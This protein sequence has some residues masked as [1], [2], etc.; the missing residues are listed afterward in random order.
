MSENHETA[1]S[2][3]RVAGGT[4]RKAVLQQTL[5]AA[6]LAAIL[7]LPGCATAPAA[8]PS[9]APPPAAP[10]GP[11]LMQATDF[12]KLTPK[13]ASPRV[14]KAHGAPRAVA[15]AGAHTPRAPQESYRS[16]VRRQGGDA[17]APVPA[18]GLVPL[19]RA[20]YTP[21]PRLETPRSDGPNVFGSVALAIG[22][23]PTESKWRHV[24]TASLTG[25]AGPWAEVLSRARG[26]SREQ[27][28][29]VVNAWVNHRIRFVDD[30]RLYRVSDQWATAA[31]SLSSG[32]GDCEDYAIAKLQMLRALGV[33]TDDLY[34]V[35]AR[36]LVRRQD[37]ALLAM[38]A[39][40]QMWILDSGGDTVLRAEQV[41][42]YLPLISYSG[43]RSWIHGRRSPS[44]V[45]MADAG[46]RAPIAAR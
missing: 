27:Q 9:I 7:A 20:T 16:I 37:H 8:R 22:H 14:A 15:R 34:L 4:S 41:S 26:L 18:S 30:A 31:E 35:I 32:Q 43:S 12:A 13:P 28:M 36:D 44:S 40:G 17:V 21:A 23:T 38:R 42:D 46:G 10:A 45:M 25:Q 11:L 2:Q 24:A 29:L 39:G 1:F 33:P 19:V 6:A 3:K 5:G